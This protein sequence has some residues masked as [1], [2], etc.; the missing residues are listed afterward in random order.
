MIFRL[1]VIV[2]A[3]SFAPIAAKAGQPFE[4][5]YPNVVHPIAQF[6]T[7]GSGHGEFNFHESAPIV[8]DTSDHIYIAD[9]FNKRIQIFD[10]NGRYLR[11]LPSGPSPITCP[12][13]LAIG[14]D[15]SLYVADSGGQILKFNAS[16][17]FI[18]SFANYGSEA[19]QLIAP[20]NLAVSKD[21]LYVADVGNNRIQ[22]FST[23]G[24]FLMAVG[25]HGRGHGEFTI[26]RSVTVDEEGNIYVVDVLHR[27]Q[28][29]S[30]TGEYILSW[31]E[32]GGLAGYLA[33]PSDISYARG[34]LYVADLVNH[35]IQV[36]TTSGQYVGQ[37]GRH[38]EIEH[39]GNGRTHYPMNVKASPNGNIATLCEPFEYRCQIFDLA[40]VRALNHVDVSAWWE[41]FPK[42]HYGGG[43]RIARRDKTI[44]LRALNAGDAF[45][46]PSGYDKTPMFQGIAKFKESDVYKKEGPPNEILVI[47]EPDIHKVAAFDIKLNENKLNKMYSVGSFGSGPQ[48]F[49]MLSAKAAMTSGQLLIGDAGANVIQ[50]LD[51]MTG[52]YIQSHFSPG[53]GPGQFNGPSGIAEAPN[54]DR[55]IG[56]FHNNRI[57]VFDKNMKFLFAFGKTGAANGEMFG[58]MS[59]SFDV[60]GEKLYVADTG[61]SRVQVFDRKGKFLWKFGHH[62]KPGE[63][64]NGTFQWPFD[65]AVAPTGEVYVTDPSLQLVQKFNDKGKFLLQWGGW[66]TQPGQFY[67]CKGID[68]D[69]DGRVFVIDFGNHRGQIFDSEGKFLGIF[70]EGEL[71]PS[72]VLDPDTGKPKY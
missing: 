49:N 15:S 67:K 18:K 69:S 64:G 59:L 53:T 55:Y 38:P 6:G 47:T 23:E 65:L 10:S 11:Q 57:Q 35:R 13:G 16:G 27:V 66:G 1:V 5:Q 36:F 62:T 14:S 72:R 22:V 21:K 24:D 51:L 29:F 33:E 25:R 48:K 30:K 31:G 41:K 8:I 3:V 56:D 40:A 45:D 71:F 7:F 43:A 19:G 28:K 9:C 20:G 17:Q 26:P 58:P 32:Y 63:W 50:E 44:P 61:N 52:D 2:C 34:N 37:W 68:V 42:F 60:K 39:E 12:Q 70:G 4:A 54:G 46:F